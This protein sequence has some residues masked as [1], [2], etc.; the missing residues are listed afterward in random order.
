MSLL[1]MTLLQEA[2]SI[3]D[4]AV[5]AND[6][7]NGILFGMFMMGVFFIMLFVLKRYGFAEAFVSSSFC[8]FIMT[9]IL[10]YGNF[11]NLIFP[12]TFLAATAF[13]ALYL[14]MQR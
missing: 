4:L 7:T 2:V 10:A 3:T 13:G 9:V 1:N 14:Y 6:S 5:V 11:V 12:L 8:C